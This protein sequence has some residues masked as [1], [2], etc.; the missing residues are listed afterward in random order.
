MQV[1][2]PSYI[3]GAQSI[4]APHAQRPSVAAGREARPLTDELTLSATGSSVDLARELPAIRAERV[5]ALKAAISA[6][7]YETQARLDGA[8]DALLDEI[9]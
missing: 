6:G 7:T 9:G 8:L 1:H 3:H 2:G 5:N 4:S